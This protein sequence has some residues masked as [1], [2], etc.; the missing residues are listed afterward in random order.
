MERIKNVEKR[1]LLL[2][3]VVIKLPREKTV[4]MI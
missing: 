2:S 1:K 4:K 3:F